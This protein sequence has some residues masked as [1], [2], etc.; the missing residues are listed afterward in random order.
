M[1]MRPQQEEVHLWR[2]NLDGEEEARFCLLSDSEQARAERFHFERDKR[3]WI[4]GRSL[5]RVILGRSL[6]VAPETLSFETGPWGKPGLPGCPL[7][8][9]VS[10]SGGAALLALAWQQEVGVDIEAV[11]RDLSGEE[12]APQVLSVRERAWLGGHA[13]EQRSRAFLTLWT[14]KEAYVK[15][16]GQGLS[17][18]LTRLTLLPNAG[19]D[20]FHASSLVSLCPISVCQVGAGPDYLA[21]LALEGAPA[22]VQHFDFRL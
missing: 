4:T 14:A 1:Q 15:A 9:N 8:F 13:P 18:P 5:L 22:R 16:T 12:L 17:F 20:Q 7:R 3:R 11:H 6:G 2:L 21:A 10:H 19:T